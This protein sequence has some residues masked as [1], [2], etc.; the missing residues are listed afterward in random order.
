MLK[1]A[2]PRNKCFYARTFK[3]MTWKENIHNKTC[4]NLVTQKFVY[5]Q[6]SCSN[7]QQIDPNWNKKHS[8][9]PRFTSRKQENKQIYA[10]S[11]SIFMYCFIPTL[12]RYIQYS[13][14][15][16]KGNTFRYTPPALFV[17]HFLGNNYFHRIY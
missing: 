17:Q 12:S 14:E 9:S 3:E 8:L 16:Q 6:T 7:F 10:M 4:K 2:E 15:K 5:A 13:G 1:I 11:G